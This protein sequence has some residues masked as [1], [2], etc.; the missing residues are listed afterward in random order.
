MKFNLTFLFLLI[1][2]LSI[3]NVANTQ[4]RR[5]PDEDGD[6]DNDDHDDDDYE[7]SFSDYPRRTQFGIFGPLRFD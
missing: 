4:F 2:L 7:D 5:F 1:G 6:V 3:F